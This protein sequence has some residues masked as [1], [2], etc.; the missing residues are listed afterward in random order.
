MIV[1]NPYFGTKEINRKISLM[2]D[3]KE[4]TITID[5]IK[6]NVDEFTDVQKSLTLHIRDL[7][8]KIQASQF[9]IQQY[10][11]ARKEALNQLLSEIH[12]PNI[13]AFEKEEE[14]IT[15]P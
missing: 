7:S 15:K 3:Q 14:G 1:I 2:E 8:N 10:E 6:Y 9:K 4:N 11:F 13:A 5:S 12:S